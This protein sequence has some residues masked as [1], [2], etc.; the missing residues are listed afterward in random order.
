MHGSERTKTEEAKRTVMEEKW[1]QFGKRQRAS[2]CMY[3]NGR[4]KN[5]WCGSAERRNVK[6]SNEVYPS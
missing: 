5:V 1:K 6:S 2:V 4:D 3:A